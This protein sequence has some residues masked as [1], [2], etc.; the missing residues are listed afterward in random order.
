M[1]NLIISLILLSSIG[2]SSASAGIWTEDFDDGAPKGWEEVV[3]KWRVEKGAY[4]EKDGPRY[5]KLMFGDV[6][7][8]DYSVEVEVTVGDDATSCNCLGLLVRADETGDNAMRFWIRTD[9]WKC[10]VSRWKPGEKFEHIVD[11]I[12]LDIE[13]GKTYHLKVIADGENYQFF[14]DGDKVFDDKDPQNSR[15]AGRIGFIAHL[16][17]P[18]FDN[19]R[20]EGDEIPASAVDAAGKLTTYWGQ[21]KTR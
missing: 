5:A 12:D 3:G 1:R 20:I 8:T 9:E 15:K 10:Q 18:R 16:T 6:N 11:K 17:N 7:W 19:L 21:I 13:S 14:V 2:I 4:A